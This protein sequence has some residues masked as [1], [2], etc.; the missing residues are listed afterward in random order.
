MLWL[1]VSV[2]TDHS[3]PRRLTAAFE[4]VGDHSTQRKGHQGM[5]C[6][7]CTAPLV[8]VLR[9]NGVVVWQKQGRITTF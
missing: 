1:R 4:V 9:G 5:P 2:V 3:S 8:E 6:P 7:Q